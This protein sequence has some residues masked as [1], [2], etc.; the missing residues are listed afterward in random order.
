MKKSWMDVRLGMV[1][2]DIKESVIFEEDYK[3]IRDGYLKAETE[4]EWQE[5]IEKHDEIHDKELELIRKWVGTLKTVK[6]GLI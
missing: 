5:L 4:E 6:G 1:D 2:E 3:K